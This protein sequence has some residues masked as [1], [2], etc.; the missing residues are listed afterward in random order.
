[1]RSIVV[2]ID[3]G[4]MVSKQN[5]KSKTII[6]DRKEKDTTMQERTLSSQYLCLPLADKTIAYYNK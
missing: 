5:K 2:G 4:L 3:V 6:R 1:M